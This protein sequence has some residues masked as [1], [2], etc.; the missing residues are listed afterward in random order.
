MLLTCY[1]TWH[2]K[3]FRTQVL[4]PSRAKGPENAPALVQYT[5]K[6]NAI[7]NQEFHPDF[8]VAKKAPFHGT[9]FS[10]S[11][12]K[13]HGE[14][15]WTSKSSVAT[16]RKKIRK[17]HGAPGQ[18]IDSL[19]SCKRDIWVFP[20]IGGFPPKWMVKIMENPIKM[21]D[22]GGP[23]LFLETPIFFWGGEK[24][25]TEKS[26]S[27]MLQVLDCGSANALFGI[28]VLHIGDGLSLSDSGSAEHGRTLPQW[29]TWL[30]LQ[31]GAIELLN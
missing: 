15:E 6:K 13:R 23:P 29:R 11:R 21:D 24:C 26:L 4:I 17:K 5:Y 9:N 18:T 16:W 25:Q 7:L 27:C 2:A 20:K 22:L 1:H 10:I 31:E 19:D 14:W 30:P 12:K 28:A 3:L 8:S